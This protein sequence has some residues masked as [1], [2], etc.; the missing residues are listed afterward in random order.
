M[1]LCA[2]RSTWLIC[3]CNAAEG[4]KL[5]LILHLVTWWKNPFLNKYKT[6]FTASSCDIGWTS[7]PHTGG[8]YKFFSAMVTW[9]EAERSCK[10]QGGDLPSITD[11]AT[12]DFL[13]TLSEHRA[14]IGL[15]QQPNEGS[16]RHEGAWTDGSPWCFQN[17]NEN[18]PNNVRTRFGN[19]ED[20]GITNWPTPTE[21]RPGGWN[22]LHDGQK[23]GYFCQK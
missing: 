21:P 7:F 8:C 20:F 22:D 1:V 2:N 12:N 23:W 17:W 5:S 16:W 10:S 4:L 9:Q 3:R 15:R 13:V 18:E 14:W 11:K 19:N 6:V